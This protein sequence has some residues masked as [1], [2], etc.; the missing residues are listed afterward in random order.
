VL[1]KRVLETVIIDR[2]P[3]HA[4]VVGTI[5]ILIFKNIFFEIENINAERGRV[6]RYGNEIFKYIV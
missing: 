3:C 5:V 4:G 2:D 1:Y 6:Y